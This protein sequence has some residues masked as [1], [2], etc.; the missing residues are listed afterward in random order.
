MELLLVRIKKL[1]MQGSGQMTPI[2]Q[3]EA[4]L[5]KLQDRGCKVDSTLQ[6]I[7]QVYE[8]QAHEADQRLQE[9]Q[10]REQKRFFG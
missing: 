7:K 6:N 8:K 10:E 3:L 4:G 9:K 2:N 5:S 1:D